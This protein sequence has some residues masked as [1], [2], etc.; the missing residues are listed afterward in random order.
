MGRERPREIRR[1]RARKMK[2]QKL[3]A[4]LEEAR[5]PQER[6][7]LLDKLYRVDPWLRPVGYK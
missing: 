5:D 6:A 2:V 4:Q 3:K 1:R 7:R